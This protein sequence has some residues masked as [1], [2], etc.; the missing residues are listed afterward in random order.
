MEID[1]SGA[2]SGTNNFLIQGNF[3]GT[4]PTGMLNF[5]NAIGILVEG[6]AV[7]QG[8]SNITIGGT[9]PRAGNVI[10]NESLVGVE[11]FGIAAKNNLVQGNLIGTDPKGTLRAA[12]G[13]V[14]RSPAA[15]TTTS[16]A[17]RRR[18]PATSSAAT[19]KAWSSPTAPPPATWSRATTSAPMSRAAWPWAIPRMA[20]NCCLTTATQSAAPRPVPV[21][22]SRAMA[23]PAW[24]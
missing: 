11:I 15:P 8:V 6:V 18:Q 22:S 24:S 7:S 5:G 4:D 3:F 17:A 19:S 21:M 20:S 2:P 14:S 23:A 13:S 9:A 1:D 12:T 16:S 10:A